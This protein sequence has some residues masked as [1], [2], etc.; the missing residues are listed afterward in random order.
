MISNG[1]LEEH[2][3]GPSLSGGTAFC[4][5]LDREGTKIGPK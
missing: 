4:W 2:S 1:E 5:S 3:V